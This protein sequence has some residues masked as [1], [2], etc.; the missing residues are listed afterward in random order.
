MD[1][2]D[3]YAVFET[4]AVAYDQI[5]GISYSK[6]WDMNGQPSLKY[7]HILIDCQPDYTTVNARSSGGSKYLPI[8]KEY[9]IK[10]FLFDK[11]TLTER[12]ETKP[13]YLALEEKQSEM[14]LIFERYLAEVQRYFI[15]VQSTNAFIKN[16]QP[17]GFFGYFNKHNDK[18]VEIFEQITV[19]A[20]SQC[21]KGTFTYPA[22]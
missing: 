15:D 7:P 3:I 10:V 2:K 18:L 21:E 12:N 9:K 1:I 16:D 19:V 11:W 4:V 14:Q 6:V 22:P 13:E 17:K 5:E 20:P 8:K